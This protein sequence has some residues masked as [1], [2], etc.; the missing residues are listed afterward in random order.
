ML[1]RQQLQS[2]RS[3]IP[4]HQDL[5]RPISLA[6][7]LHLLQLATQPMLGQQT[8]H[9]NFLSRLS[10]RLSSISRTLIVLLTQ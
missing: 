3:N 8:A 1:K 4:Q 5:L 9:V 6:R 10:R 7:T 2:L